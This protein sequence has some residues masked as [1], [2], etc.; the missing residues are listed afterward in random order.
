MLVNELISKLNEI[1]LVAAVSH[2]IEQLGYN[3]RTRCRQIPLT[4]RLEL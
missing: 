1:Y 2:F 4:S 3:L